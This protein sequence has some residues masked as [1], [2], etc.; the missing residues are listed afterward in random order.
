[1]LAGVDTRVEALGNRSD[2]GEVNRA[3]KS[4]S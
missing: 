1:M 2:K 4:A 3:S